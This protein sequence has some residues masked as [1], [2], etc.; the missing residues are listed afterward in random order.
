MRVRSVLSRLA[1]RLMAF[2]I[3]LVFLPAAG[4]LFLGT[5]ERHMVE[6]QERTMVQEGRLL[7]AALS[8]RGSL[9]PDVARRMLVQLG[10]RH[11]ARLRVVD[12]E[13]RLLA[14]SAALGP[15]REPT[16]RGEEPAAAASAEPQDSFLYRLGA[17]PFRLLRSL[18]GPPAPAQ[19]DI[20]DGAGRLTGREVADA[21]AG[22]YGA[23]TRLSPDRGSMT[24]Y[25]A[26]PVRTGQGIEGAVLVSQ[27]TYR[28]LRALYA[29]R[30]GVFKVVL[31]SLAV[32]VLL[33]LVAGTTV[34]R[35]L[36]RLRRRAGEI[37]DRRGR[38][39]GGFR[40]SGRRDEI[41][42]L[43][44]ALAELTARLERHLRQMESFAD[45]VSHEFK[46][47]LASISSATELALD[48]D[49]PAE[50]RR[51][52][53]VVRREVGHMERLLTEVREIS[54]I[55]AQLEGE[56]PEVVRLATILPGVVEAARLR[57]AD[58]AKIELDLHGN[59]VVVASP[60]RL[61][62]V[63]ENLIDNAL[64]FS[65]PAGTVEVTA[66]VAGSDAVVTVT[67]AGPGVPAEHLGR[68]FDRFFSYRPEG[69]ARSHTGLGLAIV[70]SVVESC[71]GSVSAANRPEGGAIFEVRLPLA[72]DPSS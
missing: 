57:V 38:L 28:I 36:A 40:P 24:L 71:G 12:R 42:D 32:A 5:Y 48:V 55:D 59:P 26:I 4:V 61:V 23:A 17:A 6:A 56:E 54:H 2:N 41:G 46:N 33:S 69:G 63:F 53:E 45:D 31:A 19:G 16:A 27:S 18:G 47:P 29:V 21:L 51:F 37:L 11:E 15:R 62:Q 72:A 35:P 34:V 8:V 25:C 58:G 20:Y 10:Q 60:D 30:I 43:E 9:D 65:P 50:R 3:L 64:G 67:D 70:R 7:A 1:V 22:R 39:L 44:R 13:G 68:V 52:L 14:D 49:D 66:D